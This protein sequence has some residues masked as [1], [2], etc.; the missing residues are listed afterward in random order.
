MRPQTSQHIL[1]RL[2]S[3]TGDCGAT[4]VRRGLLVTML[5]VVR[6]LWRRLDS[7][8]A[9]EGRISRRKVGAFRPLCVSY[10]GS[11]RKHRSAIR[12]RRRLPIGG[13]IEIASPW[14]CDKAFAEGA[15]E[16]ART[17]PVGTSRL[18]CR[19]RPDPSLDFGDPTLMQ[20]LPSAKP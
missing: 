12:A 17:W 10:S 5:N 19:S 18:A 15:K 16:I 4:T 8:S 14:P 1:R 6:L 3:T 7:S 9:A 20:M 13:I 2:N 11:H